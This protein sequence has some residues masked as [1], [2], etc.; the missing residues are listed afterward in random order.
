MNLLCVNDKRGSTLTVIIVITFTSYFTA[1]YGC[2]IDSDEMSCFEKIRNVT[3]LTDQ[4]EEYD[5][6]GEVDPVENMIG[7]SVFVWVHSYD[8]SAGSSEFGFQTLNNAWLNLDNSSD[9]AHSSEIVAKSIC[10]KCKDPFT[11]RESE[12]EKI[13]DSK[14]DQRKFFCF[15]SMWLGLKPYKREVVNQWSGTCKGH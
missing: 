2:N 12:N 1:P 7:S 8:C 13:K 14:R 10:D 6:S 11:P 4:A 5:Q 3:V 9:L 15:R